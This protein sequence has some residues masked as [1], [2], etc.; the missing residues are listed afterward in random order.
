M[1]LNHYVRRVRRI[2]DLYSLG[3]LNDICHP[4]NRLSERGHNSF[5]L[6]SF[7][8]FTNFSLSLSYQTTGSRQSYSRKRPKASFTTQTVSHP[9]YLVL[10]CLEWT[11]RK[12]FP[13]TARI[14]R[15]FSLKIMYEIDC[16]K[17]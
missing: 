4:F 13:S 10:C 16:G 12:V 17:S 5:P 7:L 14:Q 6:F 15:I 9:D 2:V 11:H 3:T 1:L 8:I